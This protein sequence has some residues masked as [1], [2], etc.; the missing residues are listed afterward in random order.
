MSGRHWQPAAHRLRRRARRGVPDA[1]QR[2][3]AGAC[4]SVALHL[5][6]RVRLACKGRGYPFGGRGLGRVLV[7]VQRRKSTRRASPCRYCDCDCDCDSLGR[8]IMVSSFG[9]ACPLRHGR[10]GP[11]P[12]KPA[13]GGPLHLNHELTR[14]RGGRREIPADN[15]ANGQCTSWG[16]A[17]DRGAWGRQWKT[18]AVIVRSPIPLTPPSV[19]SRAVGPRGG[20]VAHHKPAVGFPRARVG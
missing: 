14:P 13:S 4:Q 18:G 8:G 15:D 17:G 2:R 6:L 3:S 1:P 7:L 12:G 5:R 16:T 19:P 9:R 11:P 10:P 20:K